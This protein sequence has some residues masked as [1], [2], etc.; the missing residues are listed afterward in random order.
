M[1]IYNI[2]NSKA[3]F[4]RL[5]SCKGAVDLVKENG[6]Q[7]RLQDITS[8]PLANIQGSIKQME[9]KFQEAEDCQ[10]IFNYLLNSR[11]L[12]A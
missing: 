1:K 12:T 5:A 9:L 11:N 2:N 8:L 3:L 4:E 10:I 7:I 6:E